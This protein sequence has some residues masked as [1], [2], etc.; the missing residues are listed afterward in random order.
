MSSAVPFSMSLRRARAHSLD[1]GHRSPVKPLGPEPFSGGGVLIT[2][3]T[4]LATLLCLDSLFPCDSVLEYDVFLDTCPFY[5]AYPA[6]WHIVEYRNLL[7]LN[8]LIP[9]IVHFFVS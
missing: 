4:F 3:S 1:T 6:C 8:Y 2:G 7:Y 9:I 5:L